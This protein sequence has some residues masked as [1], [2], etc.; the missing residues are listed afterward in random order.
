MIWFKRKCTVIFPLGLFVLSSQQQRNRARVAGV[1]EC[2]CFLLISQMNGFSGAGCWMGCNCANPSSD[3]AVDCLPIYRS[4]SGFVYWIIGAISSAAHI[5]S[6]HTAGGGRMSAICDVCGF[7]MRECRLLSFFFSGIVA[8][9]SAFNWLI[10]R[11]MYRLLLLSNSKAF[12][13]NVVIWFSVY[14]PR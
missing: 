8:A 3:S 14:Y 6:H 10:Q 1:R 5:T 13:F 4:Q 9:I 7:P 2:V 11:Y 12:E